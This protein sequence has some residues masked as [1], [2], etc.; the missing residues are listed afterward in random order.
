[1]AEGCHAASKLLYALD[2]LQ[3]LHV[4]HCFNFGWIGAYAVA[5]DDNFTG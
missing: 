5:T 3:G 1:M 2:V 4:E